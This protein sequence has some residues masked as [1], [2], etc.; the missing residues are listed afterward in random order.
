MLSIFQYIGNT[1][2]GGVEPILN[3]NI[4]RQGSFKTI[5]RL[6]LNDHVHA[7]PPRTGFGRDDKEADDTVK[8]K[9]SKLILKWTA[10]DTC[11]IC[12]V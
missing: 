2:I 7:P 4:L 1:Y 5:L 3:I 10:N 11:D 9:G 8:R 6:V 12:M